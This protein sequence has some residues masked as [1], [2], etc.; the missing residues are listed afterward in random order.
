MNVSMQQAIEQLVQRFSQELLIVYR[1][2]VAASL[3]FTSGGSVSAPAPA[4]ASASA[5]ASPLGDVPVKRRRG[6]PP[7]SATAERPTRTRAPA[8]R[9][10]RP[11]KS[12]TAEKTTRSRGSKKGPKSTPAEVNVLS[13]RIVEV[14]RRATSRLS[15]QELRVAVNADLGPFQYA[16]NKLKATGEVKQVGDRRLAKYEIG[17]GKKPGPKGRGRGRGKAAAAESAESAAEG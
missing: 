8:A 17:G 13:N 15:A 12:A 7:K 2:A 1:D 6:R 11:R 16:L 5:S 4:V 10:G 3:G 9:R 14:L